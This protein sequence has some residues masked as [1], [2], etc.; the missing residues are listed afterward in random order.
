M[1]IIK[2]IPLSHKG[3]VQEASQWHNPL[4]HLPCTHFTLSHA[5]GITKKIRRKLMNDQLI[6]YNI[7]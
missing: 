1:K 6:G 3:P 4:S 2:I 5:D 7:Q